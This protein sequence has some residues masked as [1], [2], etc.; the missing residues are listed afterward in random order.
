MNPFTVKKKRSLPVPCILSQSSRFGYRSPEAKAQQTEIHNI[1]HST[2]AQ[3]KLTIGQPNDKYEQEAD[4]VAEQVMRMSDADVAQRVEAGI[5]QPMKIQRACTECEEE[6]QRQPEEEEEMLR[7]KGISGQTP[8]V[9]PSI[10]SRINGLKG[11]G[12][13]LDATTRSY[14]EPRFGHDFNHVRVHTDRV[15]ADTAKS[16]HA[17]AFT[18][19]SDIWLGQ[20]ESPHDVSLMAHEMTHV[21]Q[22]N[23]GGQTLRRKGLQ[24]ELNK[25]L[26]NWAKKNDKSLDPKDKSY[27]FTLQEY[28]YE[29]THEADSFELTKKP[30]KKADIKKWEKKFKKAS[31]LTKMIMKA[32]KVEQKEDRVAMI[33]QDLAA[34]GFIDE[35]MEAA[36]LLTKKDHKAY[37]YKSVLTSGD[38]A[39][40]GHLVTVTRFLT[41]GVS[42]SDNPVINELKADESGFSKALGNEK[43]TAILD[44]LV[45]AYKLEEELIKVLSKILVFNPWFRKS[46]SK[47]MWTKDK[48]FLF[49]VIDSEYFTEPEYGGSAF[50][51]AAGNARE[52]TMKGDMPWVYSV[53]Q[54][55]YVDYLVGL[56]ARAAIAIP[57]PKNLKFATLRNWLDKNTEKIG[58]VL[59]KLYAAEP[60]NITR[61]YE[62]IADIFFFHVDREGVNPDLKGKLGKL[63]PA[64][65]RKMR[66]KVDCDVFATY[67]MRILKSSGFAAIGYMAVM[68]DVGF[69]HAA[70]L[71]EKG[72]SY[73]VVNNKEVTKVDAKSKAEAIR[74]LRNDA[75]LVWDSKPES[76]KIYYADAEADGAMPKALANTEE[77]TRREDLE[78]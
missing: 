64:D 62:H 71:L 47:W 23:S 52:L 17:R 53:K 9:N 59:N 31:L 33:A 60:G 51:D 46:F 66:M 56:S 40:V 6:I 8:N 65:P 41:N 15:S 18:M 4:R 67:S 2:S 12:K 69:G 76:Y 21:V 68:P 70:A 45:D 50:A 35:A 5:V 22:Q 58:E 72:A 29:L 26:A 20:N 14:F 57:R 39:K 37:I 77:S 13:P 36:A 49:K 54:K 32:G 44:I 78:P 27:A 10:E 48:D 73:Y 7:A 61:V 42:I 75:L 16:I 38:K 43:L 1:L 25:E 34:V 11:G 55:Y 3:A 24:S 19:G 74:K 28:A 30:K 63:G